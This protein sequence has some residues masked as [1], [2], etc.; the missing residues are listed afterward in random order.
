[1]IE[2]EILK[3]CGS[4]PGLASILYTDN[5]MGCSGIVKSV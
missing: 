2:D 4:F 5:Q 3:I 1:M